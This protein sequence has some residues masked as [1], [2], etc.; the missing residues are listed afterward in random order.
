MQLDARSLKRGVPPRTR[1]YHRELNGPTTGDLKFEIKC[2]RDA[3]ITSEDP[4]TF[5]FEPRFLYLALMTDMLDSFTNALRINLRNLLMAKFYITP[6]GKT[7]TE[8][9]LVTKTKYNFLLKVYGL[10]KLPSWVKI[11][12]NEIDASFLD[13]PLMAPLKF[14]YNIKSSQS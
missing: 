5:D 12:P 1:E 4:R 11:V 8:M 2:L 3:F 13:K 10:D 7:E 14:P 6:S 9:V